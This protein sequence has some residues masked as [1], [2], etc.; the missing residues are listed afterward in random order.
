MAGRVCSLAECFRARDP[1]HPGVTHVLVDRERVAVPISATMIRAQPHRHRAYLADHVHAAFVDRIAIVGGESSGKSTLAAALGAHFA[2]PFVAE[3]GRELWVERGGQ[4]AFDDLLQIARQQVEQEERA[5]LLAER[6]VF[7]D[8]TPATTLLYCR[9]LFG[10]A[11]PELEALAKRQYA[12]HVLCAPDFAFVQDGTRRDAAF[13]DA[14]HAWYLARLSA[15]AV[16][17]M[18]AEGS[19]QERIRAVGERLAEL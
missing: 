16:P 13:R 15:G 17:W 2:T 9:D 14:Q 4:L 6:F 5:A 18:L 7:C 11:P 19:L 12:L 8:T 3:Y 1:Q 10:R